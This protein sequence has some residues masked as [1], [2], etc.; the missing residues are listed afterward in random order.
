MGRYV[1]LCMTQALDAAAAPYSAPSTGRSSGPS[2][3][4]LS[5][6]SN[7]AFFTALAKQRLLHGSR[8]PAG[9]LPDLGVQLRSVDLLQRRQTA[10]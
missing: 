10:G 1:R 2:C 6:L 4:L 9:V 5:I 3:E 7:A 8:V